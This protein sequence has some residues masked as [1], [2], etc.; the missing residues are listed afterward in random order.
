MI[1]RISL[2]MGCGMVGFGYWGPNIVRNLLENRDAR[3]LSLC[4]ADPRRLDEF[5]R[6]YPG[7]KP[8]TQLDDLLL[9]PRIQAVF[10]ATPPSTHHALASRALQAGKHVL[11]E[12]PLATSVADAE[13]L[14][15]QAEAL[16]L[17]LMPGHT[18]CTARRS[19]MVTPRIR[20]AEPLALEIADFIRAIKTGEPP[21]SDARIGLEVVRAI[22]AAHMSLNDGGRPIE[23]QAVSTSSGLMLTAEAAG[24]RIAG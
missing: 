13:D 12:K 18:S 7:I 2:P 1:G 8:T 14:I 21:R 6:R 15:A 10:L 16:D 22:E 11:V 23:T 5:Q 20:A 4:D 19:T 3:L 17:I 24:H 9:D